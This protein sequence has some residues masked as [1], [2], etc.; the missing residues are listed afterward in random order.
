MPKKQK[1]EKH[2]LNEI[3]EIEKMRHVLRKHPDLL[4]ILEVLLIICNDR[5]NDEVKKVVREL[6]ETS[7]SEEEP[8]LSDHSS[9]EDE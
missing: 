4:S 7:E 8:E 3:I 6:S 1:V 9:D 5:L 2:N